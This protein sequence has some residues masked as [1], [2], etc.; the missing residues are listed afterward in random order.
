[1][2]KLIL[3]CCFLSQIAAFAGGG[4]TQ[5]KG[6]GFFL[7][8][9]RMIVGTNYFNSQSNIIASPGLAAFTTNLYGEYGFTDKL[10]GIF[11]SPF[12]T[13]LSREAGVDSSGNI[14]T[15]DNA[16]GFGDI[17]LGVKYKLWSKNIHVSASLTIGLATGDYTARETKTLHLGDGEYNQML[18]IHASK[19]FK[20]GIFTSLFLGYNNRTSGFS[21]E[22]HYGG[23]IGYSKNKF[24]GIL[25]IY[26]RNSLFNEKPRKDSPI[27][28]IYSDNLE[29]FSVSPQIL[30]NLKGNIGILGEAG[31]AMGSRN[32]IAA[33]SLTLGIYL[34]LK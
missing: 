7:L 34:N 19:S 12:I 6:E 26:G 14:F 22:I 29:Y 8:S 15:K 20:K 11:Y 13:A 31:F 9:Q 24:T 4:W 2:K 25:K 30:Y 17:D 23:E 33:P 32:I 27:P 18:K 5:K 1:M 21:D 10:T 3:L 28:G 16:L